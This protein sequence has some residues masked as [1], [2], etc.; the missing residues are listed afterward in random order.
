MSEL[1]NLKA[2]ILDPRTQESLNLILVNKSLILLHI[3]ENLER[4]FNELTNRP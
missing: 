2:E 1:E 3:A 4:I